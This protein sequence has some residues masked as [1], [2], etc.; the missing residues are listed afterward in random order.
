[1]IATDFSGFSRTTCSSSTGGEPYPYLDA[2]WEEPG[3]LPLL[4]EVDGEVVGLCLVR[5]RCDGWSIAEFSSYPIG[6]W[7]CLAGRRSTRWQRVHG[8]RGPR[9]RSEG[10]PGKSSGVAVLARRRLQRGRGARHRCD[11][12]APSRVGI[13][14]ASVREC[15]PRCGRRLVATFNCL[16]GQW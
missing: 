1:M 8:Q 14:W 10:S 16:A 11:R 15:H 12:H 2:Y 4:V 7:W 5:R 9:S 13:A 6:A 3:R